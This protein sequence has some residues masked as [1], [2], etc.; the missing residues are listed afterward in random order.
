MNVEIG[1]KATLFQEKE[2]ISGIFVA[3]KTKPACVSYICAYLDIILSSSSR[4]SHNLA[5]I[6]FKYLP[7]GQ[8]NN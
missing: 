3:V 4:L 6:L 1:A 5:V 7:A 2:Y 8:T